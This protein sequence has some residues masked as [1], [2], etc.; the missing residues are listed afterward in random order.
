MKALK[1]EPGKA[2]ERIDVANELA[3]LQSLVGGYIEVIYPDERRPVG[4][5]CNEE[6]KCCGLELNRALYQNGKPYDIIAG[7]FLVVGLSAEDFTDLR[8]EDAAYFEKLFRS[9]EKFQRF[10]GRLVI[11]KVVPGGGETPPFSK[12][13]KTEWV[14]SVTFAFLG[15]EKHEHKS[16]IQGRK[17]KF[18]GQISKLNAR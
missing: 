7:T 6:G 18:E 12:T 3:S 2:P 9:P 17:F 11:S 1:I 16:E 10:A 4:L 14:F 15:F 8:E 13:E 5:I